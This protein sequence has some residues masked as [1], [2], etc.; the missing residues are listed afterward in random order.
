[1]LRGGFLPLLTTYNRVDAG[2]MQERLNMNIVNN[3]HY[4]C[5][6]TVNQ[7]LAIDDRRRRQL[8][9][10]LQL[11]QLHGLAITQQLQRGEKA[12][13]NLSRL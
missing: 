3:E 13:Q 9:Y 8:V 1:M 2:K 4:F 6:L 11:H 12:T 7:Q 5:V 10:P